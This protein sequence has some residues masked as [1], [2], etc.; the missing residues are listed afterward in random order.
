MALITEHLH[1]CGLVESSWVKA[2]AASFPRHTHDEYVIGANLAGTERIWLD[3]K[4]IEAPVGSVTLYNPLAVQGSDF[5]PEGVEYISLHLDP[6]A[7]RQVI[8]DNNLD[9][10]QACPTFEQGVLQNPALF[11]AIVEFAQV[12]P[13]QGAEQEEAFVSLLCQLLERGPIKTGEQSD[14]LKQAREF[15]HTHL[16]QKLELDD[17]ARVAGLSKY[18]FVRCFKKETGLAPLQYQMQLRL[19]EARKRLRQRQHPL[20]VANALGFYDQSHFINA[21]RKVMGITPQAYSA[22]LRG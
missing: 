3:G 16:G 21:Y 2:C 20:D 17:L 7:L 22:A 4:V 13:E 10:P 8:V 9:H 12:Y 5:G 14:G 11:K 18:H 19:I 6:Q 1:A 15:M